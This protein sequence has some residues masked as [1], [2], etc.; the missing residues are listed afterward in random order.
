MTRLTSNEP[1]GA[2]LYRS[3]GWGL[4]LTGALSAAF[5]FSTLPSV[6]ATG[7]AD[8]SRDATVLRFD[9]LFVYAAVGIWA[10]AAFTSR[11]RRAEPAVAR[12][13]VRNLIDLPTTAERVSC[14]ECGSVS[15]PRWAG[16]RACRTEDPEGIEPPEISFFCPECA[17]R[18]FGRQTRR[19]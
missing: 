17:N 13:S 4:G 9:P 10:V 18:E 3:I 2:G 5:A 16:W 12:S 14:I 19:R 6:Y 15:D 8:V 1:F 7:L 11:I